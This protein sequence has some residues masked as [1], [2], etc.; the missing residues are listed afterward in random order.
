M[1]SVLSQFN[2][3]KSKEVHIEES[4][5]GK[6]MMKLKHAKRLKR[7][8]LVELSKLSGHPNYTPELSQWAAVDRMKEEKHGEIYVFSYRHQD[9]IFGATDGLG[10]RYMSANYKWALEYLNEKEEQNDNNQIAIGWL[11][12]L[13]TCHNGETLMEAFGYMGELYLNNKVV[14][15]YMKT[16]ADFA[17]VQSRGWIYQESAFPSIDVTEWDD[18]KWGD[19][20]HYRIVADL[21]LRRGYQGLIKN[22]ALDV[23]SC[24][25]ELNQIVESGKSKLKSTKSGNHVEQKWWSDVENYIDMIC[26]PDGLGIVLDL[27]GLNN[28]ALEA[29][30][31]S[32]KSS[33]NIDAEV[34]KDLQDFV[35][36]SY[37]KIVAELKKSLS[38]QATSSLLGYF[39]VGAIKAFLSSELS[40]ETDRNDAVFGVLKVIDNWPESLEAKK[41]SDILHCIWA[42]AY[43]KGEIIASPV[44]TSSHFLAGLKAIEAIEGES[45]TPHIP[46]LRNFVH[47]LKEE[48]NAK[49]YLGLVKQNEDEREFSVEIFADKEMRV[50]AIRIVPKSYWNYGDVVNRMPVSGRKYLFAE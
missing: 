46:H 30:L 40:V 7:K 37:N 9:G 20:S 1:G 10:D 23:K 5:N 17:A 43:P 27:Y 18:D 21:I 26:D 44:R 41:N 19:I 4:L 6:V 13:C 34:G 3:D 11:D 31:S 50:R 42:L 35:Q 36:K 2:S 32:N 25:D 47:D 15:N 14:N 39:A 45:I 38:Q 48:D 12:I 8:G 16:P 29:G 22:K 28:L 24:R 49:L 33:F